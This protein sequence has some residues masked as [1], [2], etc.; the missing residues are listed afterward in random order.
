[1][2]QG[3]LLQFLPSVFLSVKCN[4]MEFTTV[5]SYDNGDIVRIK[6]VK[7]LLSSVLAR[8]A[9]L[10]DAW[11]LVLSFLLKLLCNFHISPELCS[12]LNL[13][14]EYN[15]SGAVDSLRGKNVTRRIMSLCV[16]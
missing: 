9:C 12:S 16:Y 3:K 15:D 10:I 5:V 2:T 4:K 14:G 1:M 11:F 7:C 8:T 13:I 6:K